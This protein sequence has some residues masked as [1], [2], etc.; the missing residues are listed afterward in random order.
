[1]PFPNYYLDKQGL[2]TIPNNKAVKL[3][4]TKINYPVGLYGLK[5]HNIYTLERIE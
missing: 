1:M 3:V 4:A 5:N 2:E